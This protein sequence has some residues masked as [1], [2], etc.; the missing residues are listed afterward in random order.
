MRR[1]RHLILQRN[2]YYLNEPTLNLFAVPT[3]RLK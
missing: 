3:A 2:L 1:V